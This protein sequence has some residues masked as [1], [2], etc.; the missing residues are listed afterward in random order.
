MA[1]RSPVTESSPAPEFKV[2]GFVAVTAEAVAKA[3]MTPV[4]LL[5]VGWPNKF[6]VL[7]IYEDEKRGGKLVRLDPCCGWM[8]DLIKEGDHACEAHP[9]K[10]FTPLPGHIRDQAEEAEE[11]SA[12]DGARRYSGF[13]RKEGGEDAVG[14][15]YVHGGQ[16]EPP[17][18]FFRRAGTSPVVIRGAAADRVLD[19]LSKLGIL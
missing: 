15:E 12:G 16:E 9:A 4:S 5:K 8:Q 10:Y 1:R 19:I 17:S 18:F 3:A 6:L 7:E 14:M 2:G 13:G 11:S